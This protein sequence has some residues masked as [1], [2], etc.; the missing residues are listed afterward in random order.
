GKEGESRDQVGG[1]KEIFPGKKLGETMET[2]KKKTKENKNPPPTPLPPP[3]L[4]PPRADIKR[5]S[6]HDRL[7]MGRTTERVPG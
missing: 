3:S 2:P 7:D 5:L 6:V 4:L 1:V